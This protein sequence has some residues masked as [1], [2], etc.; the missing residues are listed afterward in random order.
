MKRKEIKN[1]AKLIFSLEKRHSKGEDVEKEMEK[2]IAAL[3]LEDMLAIDEYILENS[4]NLQYNIH[5][6]KK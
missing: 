6:N 2:V 3:S 5:I 4:K 1:I